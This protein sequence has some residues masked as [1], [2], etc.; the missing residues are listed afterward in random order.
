MQKTAC[1]YLACELQTRGGTIFRATLYIPIQLHQYSPGLFGCCFTLLLSFSH[2]FSHVFHLGNLLFM[3]NFSHQMV[4]FPLWHPA[5]FEVSFLN[6]ANG[7]TYYLKQNLLHSQWRLQRRQGR[8]ATSQLAS[9]QCYIGNKAHRQLPGYLPT[10]VPIYLH[11]QLASY[12][13]SYPACFE[14]SVLNGYPT[15]STLPAYNKL[16]CY[17][18]P[19]N[20]VWKNFISSIK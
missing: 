20:L 3:L 12:L 18:F 19:F 7:F 8:V 14:E 2:R 4:Q 11:C 16:I 1:L 5:T 17:R 13:P 15:Y 10:Q 9:K 6:G